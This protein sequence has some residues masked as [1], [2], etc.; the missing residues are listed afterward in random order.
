MF[1][2]TT[3]CMQ[4]SFMLYLF[5]KILLTR[6]KL[7]LMFTDS[8]MTFLSDI[9]I[10]ISIFILCIYIHANAMHGANKAIFKAY[11]FYKHT[12]KRL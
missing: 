7:S 3:V 11:H 10:H 12:G 2:D 6:N 5:C 1:E 9:Y 8:F 4:R